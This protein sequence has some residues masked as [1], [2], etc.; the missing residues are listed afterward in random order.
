MV[1][2]WPREKPLRDKYGNQALFWNPVEV[3]VKYGEKGYRSNVIEIN[4]FT[5]G[6]F[7]I[8][9]DGEIQ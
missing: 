6:E 2:E 7:T 3:E 4:P 9:K 8:N 5:E 1:I